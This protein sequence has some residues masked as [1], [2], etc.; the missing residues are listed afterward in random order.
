M[1]ACAKSLQLPMSARAKSLQQRSW[2]NIRMRSSSA[3]GEVLNPRTDPQSSI[4]TRKPRT[5]TPRSGV[6]G[7][8]VPVSGR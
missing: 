2:V 7:G 6:G 1:S 8:H 4:P 3:G 5:D